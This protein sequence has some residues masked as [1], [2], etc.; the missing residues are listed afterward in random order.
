MITGITSSGAL[1]KGHVG[2]PCYS[3]ECS[4]RIFFAGNFVVKWSEN[5]FNQVADDQTLEFVN[6]A[7][8][9]I[10]GLVGITREDYARDS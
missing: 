8:K 3:D 2:A 6:P 4:Q 10:G 7:G 9:V 1:S 5:Y